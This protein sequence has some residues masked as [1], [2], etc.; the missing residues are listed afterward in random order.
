MVSMTTSSKTTADYSCIEEVRR[1]E[2]E[3]NEADPTEC[4]P[5][6]HQI[7]I[8]NWRKNKAREYVGSEQNVS[9]KAVPTVKSIVVA[10]RLRVRRHTSKQSLDFFQS[11]LGAAISTDRVEAIL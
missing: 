6:P 8:N 10:H 1:R 2:R 7:V 11:A 5:F 4:L 3:K 9:N